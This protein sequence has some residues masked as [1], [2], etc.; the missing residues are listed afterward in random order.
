MWVRQRPA[1]SVGASLQKNTLSLELCQREGVLCLCCCADW[2]MIDI[3][4]CGPVGLWWRQQ[5]V[6]GAP[7]QSQ[8]GGPRPAK[9]LGANNA[10]KSSSM[11]TAI[12]WSKQVTGQPSLLPAQLPPAVLAPKAP[13]ATKSREQDA[14]KASTMGLPDL[15]ADFAT[16]KAVLDNIPKRSPLAQES[17]LSDLSELVT[18]GL[19]KEKSP[20]TSSR[21]AGTGGGGRAAP[22]T[23]AQN[24]RGA[25][26]GT[27]SSSVK[28]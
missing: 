25:L 12:D 26:Q 10:G 20:V 14:G 17:A 6:E 15:P 4:A 23:T 21:G 7:K 9:S 2:V 13:T 19:E 1:V 3:L 27:T 16:D 8:M 18:K 5:E 11:P 24:M 28:Q 22:G